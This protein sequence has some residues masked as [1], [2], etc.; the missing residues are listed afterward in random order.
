M[1]LFRYLKWVLVLSIFWTSAHFMLLGNDVFFSKIDVEDGLSQSS[2][3]TIFQDEFG[4]MWFGTREGL[5]LY[6]GSSI[7]IIQPSGLNNKSLSGHLIKY[8]DG[9]LQGSVF[10]HTQNGIDL[11]D[12]KTES[13]SSLIR[14]QVNAMRYGNGKLWYAKDNRIYQFDD[15]G[16]TFFSE[17]GKDAQITALLPVSDNRIIVGTL[18]SGVYQINQK[19]E[20]S[21]F[22]PPC[23]QVSSLYEDSNEGIWVSTWENG[24]YL[25]S[26]QGEVANFRENNNNPLNSISSDFVRDV[27]EDREGNIWIGTK[28]GL[29]KLNTADSSFTH[30]T[31]FTN[32]PIGLSNESVWSLYRD[33]QGNLWIGTYFGGVNNIAHESNIYDYHDLQKGFLNN[34]SFPIISQIV[35]YREDIYFLCTEGNGLIVYNIEDKTYYDYPGLTNDNI[36]TAYLDREKDILYLGLHLG[37]MVVIDLNNN[38]VTRHSVIKSGLYQSNIIRKILPYKEKLL[39]A[40]YNGLYLF[41]IESSTFTVFSEEL[42]ENIIYFI[43]IAL[44]RENN[45]WIASRGVYKYNIDS[46]EIRP[47]FNDPTDDGSLSNNNATKVYIDS[48]NKLWIG[49]SGGGINLYNYETA[50]FTKFNSRNSNLRNDYI[51]NIIESPEG[52]LYLTTTQGLSYINKGNYEVFNA[53]FHDG[54]SLNSLFNGGININSKGKVFIAGMDGMVSYFENDVLRDLQPLQL[55]FSYLTVNNVRVNPMDETNIIQHSLSFTN[56][57]K[58]N[59]SQSILKFEFASDQIITHDRYHYLYRLQGWSDEWVQLNEGMNEINLM[60][61][62]AGKYN[63]ELIAQSPISKAELGRA[64]MPFTVTPP[65]YRSTVAYIFYILIVVLL[66]SLYV[67]Y[68]KSRVRLESSLEFEKKEKEHIEAVNQSKIRFFTNISHEFRTPLTLITSQAEILLQKEKLQ[69]EVSSQISGIARNATLMKNLINELL[70]FRKFD[71]GKL[72]LKVSENNLVSFLEEIC[73]SFDEF[74]KTLKIDFNFI[75]PEEQ[76]S[77]WFDQNQMQKV[78]FNLISNAFKYTPEGGNILITIEQNETDVRISVKDNGIGI[79]P[80]DKEKIF[81][82]FYQGVDSKNRS[83]VVQGTGLGLALTKGIITAHHGDIAIESEVNEGSNFIVNLKKGSSHFKAEEFVYEGNRDEITINR[84]KGYLP[85]HGSKEDNIVE[86]DKNSNK[87]I[88]I[89]EDNVELLNLLRSLFEPVYEVITATNGE[90][91]L[92]KTFE[93]QPDIVLSD[94]M[95]PIISGIEMCH[96]IKTNFAVCHIPVVLLTAQT[97]IESNIESLKLGADD[98]ITKPFDVSVLM[99][100]CN[101]LINGRK[102]LQERYAKSTD[103]NTNNIASNDMDREFLERANIIIE[104]N[105]ENPDF[106]VNE[107]SQELNLGRTSM[108]NKIKG[109]TGQTPNDFI[110]TYKM[111]KASYMLLHNPELNI[112]DITYKLGFNSPKY[113][114]KCF[115]DQFGLSPSK[116]K[117][118]NL[119]A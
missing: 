3:M 25:I 59:H 107:F 19:G 9:D 95:M 69:P 83:Y 10:I 45:L 87:K 41:D 93:L 105:I 22:L 78:F 28:N 26:N 84:I 31:S 58:F 36:K 89:V 54:I 55:Y 112:S 51:S 71:E 35:E 37:G 88:L 63:L 81:D 101:N 70:D 24:L 61:L 76:I 30:Y 72:K 66:I 7:E 34:K 104:E 114:S 91:G 8:V 21:L 48:E 56:Q 40:T 2:V 42:H 73:T 106:G 77:L 98:Y 103:L 108:F 60:N 32:D 82:S 109:I 14:I 46:G 96:R 18:A 12:L 74:S 100:R 20:V 47:Y 99:A 52:F 39:I 29:D 115:K 53:V 11:Y 15:S 94:L 75:K 113:F 5:N 67:R 86:D 90:E 17:L 49:T 50:T 1:L 44:D 116:Y 23:S 92:V 68:I 110:I 6:N 97:A 111:K 38:A 79:S 102:V 118:N 64:E 4:T 27:T 43:D 16:S 85:Q 65:L 33:R 117:Q 57:L 80:E 62:D 119:S 13:I